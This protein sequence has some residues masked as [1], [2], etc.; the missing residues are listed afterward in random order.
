M[1]KKIMCLLLTFLFIISNIYINATADESGISFYQNYDDSIVISGNAGGSIKLKKVTII[2]TYLGKQ[3]ED[4]ESDGISIGDTL[5]YSDT[6]WTESNGGWKVVWMPTEKSGEYDVTVIIDGKKTTDTLFYASRIIKEQLESNIENGDEGTMMQVF[7]SEGNLKALGLDLNAISD[8]TDKRKIGK[9]LYYIR[10]YTN[11]GKNVLNYVE[12]AAE[13]VRF[14]DNPNDS[15]FETAV[16]VLKS[17]DIS[18]SYLDIFRETDDEVIKSNAL[19]GFAKNFTGDLTK[20]NEKFLSA[21]VLSAVEK[22]STWAVLDDYLKLIEY[23]AYDNSIYKDQIAIEI[24]GNTYDDISKLK[25]AIDKVIASKQTPSKSKSGGGGGGNRVSVP[26]PSVP[27]ASPQQNTE[28]KSSDTKLVFNDVPASHWAFE[29][30]N[31]LRWKEYVTGSD[32]NMFYPDE[33]VS[34]AEMVKMLVNAFH[35]PDGKGNPFSDV[36]SSDWFA[37]YISSA[38]SNGL[39]SG[40][41]TNFNPNT[42]ITRQDMVVMIYRFAK[43]A[44]KTFQNS[45][46]TFVDKDNISSYAEEAVAYMSGDSIICGNDGNYFMPLESATRAQ[47]AKLIYEIVK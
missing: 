38:Y 30:I 26:V 7:S 6:T 15:T 37:K 2:I 4:I 25:T 13:L 43:Y 31:Y 23:D 8:I 28:D 40:D 19:T 42:A 36:T 34:R 10:M 3:M 9:Q 5:K 17:I 46:M 44:G 16:T 14:I 47:A 29:A 45:K 24:V 27:V 39:V 32:A 22:A 41:G 20:L 21:I 35:V 18:L 11:S 33:Y 12:A 1:T